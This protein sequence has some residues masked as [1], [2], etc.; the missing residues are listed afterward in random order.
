MVLP[1]YKIGSVKAKSEK[2]RSREIYK[3]SVFNERNG[4]PVVEI[5]DIDKLSDGEEL[6]YVVEQDMLHHQ[7]NK[8]KK[9]IIR[10]IDDYEI[11]LVPGYKSLGGLRGGAINVVNYVPSNRKEIF[12]TKNHDGQL[13]ISSGS[14]DGTENP[15]LFQ[16]IAVEANTTILFLKDREKIVLP[17]YKDKELNDIIEKYIREKVEKT[18]MLG[19]IFGEDVEFEKYKSSFIAPNDSYELVIENDDGFMNF[20]ARIVPNTDES[21]FEALLE[22]HREIPDG[23]FPVAYEIDGGSYSERDVVGI[24][25]D[26]DLPVTIY[27]GGRELRSTYLEEFLD[28]LSDEY[29]KTGFRNESYCTKRAAEL[30]NVRNRTFSHDYRLESLFKEPNFSEEFVVEDPYEEEPVKN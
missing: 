15:D 9:N 20:Q 30:L 7:W 21:N 4:L 11:D 1:R 5:R 24:K 25:L 23:S 19:G 12:L 29:L 13:D 22:N 27:R 3:R 16:L 26:E 10:K 8:F 6:E 2:D 14:L 18:E 17:N 28:D